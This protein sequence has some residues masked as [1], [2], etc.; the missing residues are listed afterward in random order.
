MACAEAKCIGNKSWSSDLCVGSEG[1]KQTGC[2]E[3][4]KREDIPR[5]AS[6]D[7]KGRLGL[8]SLSNYPEMTKGRF[9]EL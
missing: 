2:G 3:K 9:G 6:M 7:P 1:K 4:L 5:K 8:G